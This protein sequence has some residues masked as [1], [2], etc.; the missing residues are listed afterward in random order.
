MTKLNRRVFLK[1][2]PL[3][4][5]ATAVP[6]TGLAYQGVT[7]SP[8][9]LP[10]WKALVSNLKTYSVPHPGG[11]DMWSVVR[12]EHLDALCEAA[13][14]QEP[15]P[16]KYDPHH[17]WLSDWKVARAKYN[18]IAEDAEEGAQLLE[19]RDELERKIMTTPATNS[20]GVIAQLEFALKDDL[21]GGQL[22]GE[23]DGMDTMMFKN[24]VR[25]LARGSV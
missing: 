12:I 16:I 7:E 24:I 5:A 20:S 3:T 10:D 1:S 8:E 18:R 9:S 13:G 21:C 25:T 23:F 14:I 4:A 15:A 19:E 6:A 11:R 2:A 17:Q 22:G